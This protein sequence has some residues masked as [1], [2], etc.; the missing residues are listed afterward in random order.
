[1]KLNKIFY[2]NILIFLLI[3]LIIF[4]L[5]FFIIQKNKILSAAEE[6]EEEDTTPPKVYNIK[7]LDISATSSVITWETDESADSLVNYGLDKNYGVTRDPYFDKISHKIILENLLPGKV[8]Y[9][10]ITSSDSEGNQ[11]ISSDYSFTT[12]EEEREEIIHE[13][14]LEDIIEEGEGGLSMEGVEEVLQAVEKITSEEVLEV[15]KEKVQEKAEEVVTPP[16]IILDMANVEVGTDY[17][18]IPWKTDKLSD[19]IVAL[20]KESNYNPDVED[21]YTWKEGEPDELVLE[22]RVEI[23]GLTPATV[24]HFQVSSKSELGL[25]GKS[26]DRNF[27]TKSILPEIYNIQLA[28]VEEESA[29]IRWMTNVPCSAIVE[30]INLNTSEAKLEGNSSYLTVHSMKL[31]NLIFDTYYSAMIKVE[32]EEEEKAE[33]ESITFIT[34]RDEYPPVISKVNTESTLYP[35][36]ENK[37]QTIASWETDELAKCQLFYHQG[38]VVADEPDFLPRE[39]DYGIKHVQVI[40]NFLPSTVYKFWIVCSDEADNI[41][42]SDDFTMLTPTQEESIIDIII[43][44]F[45]S[46]FGW[47]KKLKL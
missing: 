21:P 14:L 35:G 16:T 3:T 32:S 27:K 1:M 45:E 26:E 13:G 17:A 2:L 46:T 38:L 6:E 22:H 25:T 18:I 29:T 5:G 40:T 15:I 31:T 37:I 34:T 20:V 44:N 12:K 19:S 11:G 24:Y 23:T 30:Y 42:K 7:V 39:E 10:R 4:C 28:K 43:K 36:T 47:V 9:F 41:A 8:Y 33:S